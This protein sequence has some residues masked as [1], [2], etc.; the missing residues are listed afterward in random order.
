MTAPIKI[1]PPKF[2]L[3]GGRNEKEKLFIEALYDRA[4]ITGWEDDVDAWLWRIALFSQFPLDQ[5][6]VF[7]KPVEPISTGKCWP[8]GMTRHY[9]LRTRLTQFVQIPESYGIK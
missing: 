3:E 8:T 7:L 2:G 9:S 6:D 4:K 1:E 5:R